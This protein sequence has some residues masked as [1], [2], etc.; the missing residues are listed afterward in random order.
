MLAALAAYFSIRAK[1]EASA[2]NK[3]VNHTDASAP[4]LYDIALG[5]ATNLAAI[6]ERVR[7]V[8]SNCEKLC[9][10][11]EKHS[12]LLRDHGGKLNAQQTLLER[13]TKEG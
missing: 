3:A 6:R 4:R 10:G 7:S 13:I 5:N 2:A 11:Q 12:D 1:L 9:T 8:E